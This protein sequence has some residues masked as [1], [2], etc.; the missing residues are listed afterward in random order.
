[1]ATQVQ[2]RRGT[3]AENNEF[4]GAEGEITI[5]TTNDSIRVHDGIKKGGYRVMKGNDPI[6]PGA[7]PKI[8]YDKNGLVI[9][10]A[11]LDM[12][13]MPSGLDTKFVAKGNVKE[14]TF[15]K[16]TIS[17]DGIVTK[18]EQIAESD[19]PALSQSKITGLQAA[20]GDKAQKLSVV[21]KENVSSL[22]PLVEGK[23]NVIRVNEAATLQPP[24]VS[25]VSE[26]KQMLVQL[27]NSRGFQVEFSSV[28]G[29]F[30]GSGIPKITDAG[31]Y[32]IY[33]EY[34]IARNG[35]VCGVIKV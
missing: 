21:S 24:V 26:L 6:T 18:G 34:N 20:L 27:D 28:V 23:V 14:G 17:K 29:G 8:T 5:D 32:N 31:F 12:Q 15:T 19:V 3:E 30:G 35:W 13:D 25:D 4:T 33:F 7:Y 11:P 2:L 10:G 16:I 22:V 1:M 9:G